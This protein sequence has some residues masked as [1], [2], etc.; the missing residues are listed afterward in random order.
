MMSSGL[1]DEGGYSGVVRNMW[2]DDCCWYTNS[3]NIHPMY[4][5]NAGIHNI[6]MM[7][8]K[9]VINMNKELFKWKLN[10]I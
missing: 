5:L 6:W 9:D 1:W 8:K 2:L 3:I 4:M 10:G 7:E